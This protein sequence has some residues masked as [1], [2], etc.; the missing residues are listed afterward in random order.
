MVHQMKS[1]IKQQVL[2]FFISEKELSA[3]LDFLNIGKKKK[4]SLI[5]RLQFCLKLWGSKMH[6]E[7]MEFMF[8]SNEAITG[9]I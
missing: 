2:H 6:Q 7:H 4:I 3:I 9:N 8:N 1:V 5:Q